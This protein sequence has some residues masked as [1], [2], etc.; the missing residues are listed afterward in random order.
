VWKQ[1][2]SQIED[3]TAD[4][5]S[6]YDHVAISA[7]N[8]LVVSFKIGYT[9]QKESLERPERR[10]TVEQALASVTGKRVKVQFELLPDDES[11]KET[12]RPVASLRQLRRDVEKNAMV[13]AAIELFDAEID[14][15]DRPRAAERD[16]R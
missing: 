11:A 5:G 9:L 14:R 3:M 12:A 1:A 2:L 7:P 6:F 4:Y 16:K 8:C 13:H 15:I 10:A